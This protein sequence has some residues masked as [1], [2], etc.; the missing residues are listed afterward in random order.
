MRLQLI[1]LVVTV[2]SLAQVPPRL[3]KYSE[4]L[5]QTDPLP[6]PRTGNE[7]GVDML[8]GNVLD[9][10]SLGDFVNEAERNFRFVS[11][12]YEPR[13]VKTRKGEMTFHNCVYIWTQEGADAAVDVHFRPVRPVIR[14]ELGELISENILDVRHWYNNQYCNH[15]TGEPIKG[16]RRWDISLNNCRRGVGQPLVFHELPD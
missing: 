6:P 15:E 2:S 4:T 12:W 7:P 9:E 1:R 13:T 8:A 3:R 5:D 16:L 10:V 14:Q 11:A